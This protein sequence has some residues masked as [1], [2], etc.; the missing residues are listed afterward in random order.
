MRIGIDTTALPARPFG[1]AHYIIHLTQAVLRVDSANEYVIL[2]KPEDA[3]HFEGLGRAR[4]LS[5]PLGGRLPRL[6]WE[7]TRLPALAREHRLDLLHSPH[8]TMPLRTPCRSVVTI[9]DLT[10]F[11]YPEMHEAYKRLFFRTI[12]PRSVQRADALIAPSESTRADLLRLLHPAP[13]KVWVIPYGVADRLRPVAPADAIDRARRKW[14]LAAPFL[15]Y[16]GNLEPRKNIPLLLR[17]F[18]RLV[19][20]GRPHA[21]VFAGSPG[22][23]ERGIFRTVERLGLGERVRFLG[24]LPQEDLPVLYSAAQVF[25][26]P[27]LYE[28]FG[29]PVLEA[30]ACGVPV[31]TSNLSSMPQVA[32]DAAL[33]IDPLSEQDLAEALD[34]LL[35]DAALCADLRR[36]GLER[37][38]LFTWER[39]ARA[40]IEV[41]RS[42]TE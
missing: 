24:Y 19:D 36:R 11:L 10:F 23:Q 38:A 5:I 34:R 35:G 13:G 12:I 2:T 8:Y 9:H 31:V 22:W 18:K 30:M 7:Q 39:A 33:L 14:N 1:A 28:G 25:V 4:V 40:T 29:L 15:L 42:V 20:R 41:Y 3:A 17:A 21:L 26:Y 32:G 37:A 16:V 6:A 27:S